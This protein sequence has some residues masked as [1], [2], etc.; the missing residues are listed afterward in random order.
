[1]SRT[2]SKHENRITILENNDREQN[3]K[4]DNL[5]KIIRNLKKGK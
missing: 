2:L 1:M 5:I 3:R 4:I